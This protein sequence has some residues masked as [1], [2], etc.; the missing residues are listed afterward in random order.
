[1]L[2]GDRKQDISAEDV[3][4]SLES[5]SRTFVL[6]D[7]RTAEEH[8]E[9]HIPGDT[10]V[11]LEGK[12]VEELSRILKELAGQDNDIVLYCD[13][14]ARSNMACGVLRSLGF[15]NLKSMTGGIGVW[16]GRGYV[17]DTA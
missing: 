1:M 6:V 3:H 9:R 16:Q 5:T 14:G 12:S 13:S 10:H 4:V 2:V 15:N 7:V 11:S 17:V 8:K